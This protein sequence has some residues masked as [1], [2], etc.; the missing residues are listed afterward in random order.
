MLDS[1]NILPYDGEVYYSKKNWNFDESQVIFKSFLINFPWRHDE[2]IMFGKKIVTNRKVVWFGDEAFQYTYSHT[3]K[4]ALPWPPLLLPIKDITEKVTQ[5][6][7]NSCLCNL[8]HHGNEGMSWHSDDD[9]E[10]GLQ[11]TIA[12]LSFGA[13]RIFKFRHKKTKEIISLMLESG[14][15]LLMKGSTQSSW[16]HELPKSAKIKD[17]RINLTF[18]LVV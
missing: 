10:F 2:L 13:D 5:A 3:L 14:H 9:K 6:R 18:R 11:P 16:A 17:P 4:T 15:I 12:S 7:Y 8:Y 1:Q